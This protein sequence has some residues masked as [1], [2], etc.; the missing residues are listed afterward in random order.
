MRY[1][2]T[3]F[4]LLGIGSVSADEKTMLYD[5]RYWTAPDHTRIVIDT[6]ENAFYDIFTSTDYIILSIENAKVLSDTF[7]HFFFEDKRIE[8]T[9]IKRDHETLKLIFH[10][11]D[12][13]NVKY[14]NLPPNQKY[15]YHRLVIDLYDSKSS[16][17]KTKVA[18]E[19]ST[20]SDKI[21][22]LVDAGHGGEDYGAVGKN[23]TREKDVNLAIAK[24][25]VNTIN[26][27]KDLSAILT[28]NG[29]YYI[30]LTKRITIAKNEQA[31]MFI[32]I[33][34]DAV[35]STSAKGAS[36]YTLSEKGN[37]SKLAK[38][39]EQSENSVDQ[40]GGVETVIDSDQFLKSILTDFSRQ[41]RETQ[42]QKLA[43]QVLEELSKIGPVHKKTPQKANFVVLKAP[44]IP[45]ILV[46]TAFI[47]NPTQEKRLGN[48]KEQQK[49]ADA[50]YKGV[51]DYFE[52]GKEN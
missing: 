47:S 3:I 4:F 13:Y 19:K 44:T 14:F 52:E 31:T 46:E 33:H 1:F 18:I 29:D 2:L 43:S 21:I 17:S 35:E 5:F 27:N 9:Q 28:R 42:S 10:T 32:S 20:P 49:I 48:S 8:R 40:F 50:I 11:K 41:D 51:I 30:P 26:K 25:L 22:I 7:S 38:Q 15:K 36:I 12:L 24:K 37:N 6:Q 34:A 39:L 45:S 23:K 16:K